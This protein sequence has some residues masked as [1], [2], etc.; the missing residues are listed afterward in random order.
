[1]VILPTVVTTENFI[2]S[3]CSVSDFPTTIA[4]FTLFAAV[5]F[6]GSSPFGDGNG[7]ISGL[8]SRS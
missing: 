6:F 8:R 4:T 7:M 5:Y 1:M 3:A 2:N